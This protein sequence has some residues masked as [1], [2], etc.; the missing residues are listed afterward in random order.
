MAVEYWHIGAVKGMT[1]GNVKPFTGLTLGGTRYG[2]R[3]PGD[4]EVRPEGRGD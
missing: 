2:S 3:Q 1:K 4:P